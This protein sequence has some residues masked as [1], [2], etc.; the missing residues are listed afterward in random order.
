MPNLFKNKEDQEVKIGKPEWLKTKIS[1]GKEYRE[2]KKAV[3]EH[4]LN[5]ICE[6]G[7]CPNQAECWGAGTATFMILGDT[8]TRSCQFCNVNTGKPEEVDPFE[9]LRVAKSIKLMGLKHAVITSVDRDDLPDGGADAW[10]RTIDLIRKHNPGI[11][12]ETLI[13]DFKGEWENLKPILE[14][15]PEVVSHNVETVRRIT[16]K[17]RVQAQYDRSIEVLKRLKEGGISKTKSG[18]MLGLGEQDEEVLQTMVDLRT[19]GVSI[20][21]LGQYM[22]P[23]KK[24]LPVAEF[25]HPDKFAY[26]KEEGLKRG[27]THVESGPLVRSSY[28]AEKHV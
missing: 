21:T 15:S 9:A 10:K 11:T 13:P 1:S 7:K 14:V 4:K 25:V 19:V 17:V 3:K 27:F 20:M 12:I 26:F 16:K 2:T 6:S 5:T 24:H 18:I 28:H 8:C 22:Q 23:T